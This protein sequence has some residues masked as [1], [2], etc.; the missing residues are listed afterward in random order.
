M[1]CWYFAYSVYFAFFWDLFT[2]CFLGPIYKKLKGFE[3]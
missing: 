1:H 3:I 2:D